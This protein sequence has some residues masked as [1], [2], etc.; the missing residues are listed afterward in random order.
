[1]IKTYV[2]ANALIAAFRGDH[3]ASGEA[4]KLLGDKHRRFI[5]SAYLRLETL[6]KPHRR[7]LRGRGPKRQLVTPYSASPPPAH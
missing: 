7:R 1:M 5:A 2:D 6:R 4:L 3:P